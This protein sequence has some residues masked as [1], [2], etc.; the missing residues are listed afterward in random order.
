MWLTLSA[1]LIL[2]C[3]LARY[4][5]P[6]QEPP[7]PASTA[8]GWSGLGALAEIV[9]RVFTA[10]VTPQVM[11]VDTRPH[12]SCYSRQPLPAGRRTSPFGRV[13]SVDKRS[14]LKFQTRSWLPPMRLAFLHLRRVN[15]KHRSP[16]IA[17]HHM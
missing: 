1:E 2:V 6:R 3:D 11:N 14:H 12:C 10:L 16:F 4:S 9:E 7:S 15:C 8:G 13:A 5:G 17:H